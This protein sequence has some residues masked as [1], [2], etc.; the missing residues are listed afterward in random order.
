MRASH[1]RTSSCDKP[2]STIETKKRGSE[3]GGPYQLLISRYDLI[4]E[5]VNAKFR[6][7]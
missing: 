6:M 5:L 1:V 3:G 4:F 2:Y 7:I